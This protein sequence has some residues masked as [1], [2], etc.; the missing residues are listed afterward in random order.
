ML[1]PNV[2]LP[3]DPPKAQ[4]QGVKTNSYGR[5]AL[6][7][8][9]LVELYE[10][11]WTPLVRTAAWLLG[12]QA[13]AEE[14]TQDAFVRLVERWYQLDDADAAPAWLRRTVLNLS[15]SKIRRLVVGRHK[16][17]LVASRATAIDTSA[18]HLGDRLV[19]GDVGD[20]IRALPRRQA[21]CVV[22]RFVEDLS[23]DEIARVLAISAGSV[24]THL[25]R[26]LNTLNSALTS[27]E[28]ITSQDAVISQER[29]GEQR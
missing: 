3:T 9:R 1:Q 13:S 11:N 18:D 23:V 20:A 12:D 27:Q 22:L 26:A 5:V 19:D 16:R 21:E 15:R 14:V 8:E 17:S 24:K 7:P 4:V 2:A 6:S 25:H 29:T 28:P 10:R